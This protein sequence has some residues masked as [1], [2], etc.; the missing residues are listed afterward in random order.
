MVGQGPNTLAQDN[1]G[2]MNLMR[3]YKNHSPTYKAS[4]AGV[5]GST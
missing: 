2:F 1:T 3:N 5:N 4:T